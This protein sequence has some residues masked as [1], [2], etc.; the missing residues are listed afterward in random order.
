MCLLRGTDWAF[1]KFVLMFV[2][3]WLMWETSLVPKHNIALNYGFFNK[4][5]RPFIQIEDLIHS[6]SLDAINF[7]IIIIV[8]TIQCILFFSLRNS[9]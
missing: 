8:V 2:F 1:D 4:T 6:P 9:L 3:E 5:T 7:L